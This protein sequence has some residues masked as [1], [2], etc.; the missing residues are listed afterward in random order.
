L[1]LI[2][3]QNKPDIVAFGGKCVGVGTPF[4]PDRGVKVVNKPV[5]AERVDTGGMFGPDQ[6][7]NFCRIYGAGNF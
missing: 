3:C 4:E 5:G 7:F 1:G 2:A 6:E